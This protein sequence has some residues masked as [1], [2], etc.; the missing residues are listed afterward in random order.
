[1]TAILYLFIFIYFFYTV[2]ILAS[3]P[4]NAIFAENLIVQGN[5]TIAVLTSAYY[6]FNHFY[7]LGDPIR[8]AYVGHYR[9]KHE[10]KE[11]EI[12]KGPVEE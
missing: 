12:V 10:T 5:M 3:G 4:M 8:F 7:F 11:N 9:T 1:M 6:L 2:L